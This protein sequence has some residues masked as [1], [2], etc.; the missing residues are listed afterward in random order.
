MGEREPRMQ[1][2]AKAK[3]ETRDP[4][5]H[6][7]IKREVKNEAFAVSKGEEQEA[8]VI[9]GDDAVEDTDTMAPAREELD[10]DTLSGGD[11]AVEPMLGN[12]TGTAEDAEMAA[13]T[14]RG[15]YVAEVSIDNGTEATAAG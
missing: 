6:P 2:E 3:P 5:W 11:A 8:E 12:N 14:M 1:R 9:L 4:T 10:A 15:D 7:Y 13:E